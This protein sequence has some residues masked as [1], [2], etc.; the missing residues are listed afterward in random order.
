[1]VETRVESI[2]VSLVTQ[3]RCVVL[4]DVNEERY[5]PIWIGPYEADAIALE[6][7]QVPLSRPLTHD[8][9]RSV[10]AELGGRVTHVLISEMRDETYF[11][12]VVLDVA[13]RHVEV[14]SRSSDAIALAV[15]V[16]APIMVDDT[17]MEQSSVTISGNPI[18]EADRMADDVGILSGSSEPDA[19]GLT[20]FRD[21]INSL[22]LDDLGSK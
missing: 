6:L 17:V 4:R 21:F 15:R 12:R 10:I 16:H 7:Q 9:L 14:D 20:V 1:M 3:Q 18:T 13:G 19:A 22:D 5:L 11:A 2:R 8:L